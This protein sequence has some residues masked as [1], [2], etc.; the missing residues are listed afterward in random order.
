MQ[1]HDSPHDMTG[2]LELRVYRG[3]ELIDD[4]RDENLIVDGARDMLAR[5]IAG[6]GSGE[7]VTRIGF[8]GNASPASPDDTALTGAYVRDLTGHSYPAAGQVR[9]DFALATTEANGLTI[10]EFGL[11]AA[12][13][14][15]FSRKVR[16]AIEKNDDISFQGTWTIIF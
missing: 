1:L 9:F 14:S 16:G 3:G 7:A 2:I 4:W 11:I 5:L 13:G 6:D 8:G 10:R 12:D 15:L